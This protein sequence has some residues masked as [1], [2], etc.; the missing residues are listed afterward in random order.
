MVE[1]T[2]K[3]CVTPVR[4]PRRPVSSAAREGVHTEAPVW[5]SVSRSPAAASP[6]RCGVSEGTAELSKAPPLAPRSPQ[7][8]SSEKKTTMLGR[9]PQ[10]GP[11]VGAGVG[12]GGGVGAGAGNPEVVYDALARVWPTGEPSL[13]WQLF[14]AD[15]P[16]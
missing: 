15:V 10:C 13:W 4:R 12:G 11:G 6:S 5:K 16:S 8:V 7:P 3:L 14:S 9:E 2:P 1:A